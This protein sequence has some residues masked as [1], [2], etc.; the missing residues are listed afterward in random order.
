ML[1]SYRNIPRWDRER[2]QDLGIATCAGPQ[3]TSLDELLRRWIRSA[4]KPF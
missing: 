1:V 3:L 2:A 4:G